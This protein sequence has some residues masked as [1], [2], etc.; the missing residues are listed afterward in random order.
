MM[1]KKYLLPVI[2]IASLTACGGND[3][4]STLGL[5][6]AAP[7][8]FAVISNPP[9]SVPPAFNLNAPGEHFERPE[10]SFT[11]ENSVEAVTSKEDQEFLSEFKKTAPKSKVK[12]EIDEEHA[13]RQKA[14]SEKGVVRKA[15][16]SIDGKHEEKVIDPVSERRRI[17]DNI[18]NNVP[19]NEGEVVDKSK[20]TIE[21][22]LGQ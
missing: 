13:K 15:I 2:A 10:S 18:T 17:R 14:Q 7:D 5:K 11:S 16:N 9:L 12:K 6:K 19:I 4:K 3:I 22:V 20:S 1:I 8:E 21:R